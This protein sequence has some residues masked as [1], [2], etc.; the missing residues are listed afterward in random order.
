MIP[1]QPAPGESHHKCKEAS[2]LHGE[3]DETPKLG[4]LTVALVTCAVWRWH[5][6][7]SKSNSS[8]AVNIWHCRD[9]QP[10]FRWLE[11]LEV[12]SAAPQNAEQDE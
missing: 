6:E 7:G 2:K 12:N 1:T 4:R 3:C 9:F 11:E 5:E 8:I 10:Q